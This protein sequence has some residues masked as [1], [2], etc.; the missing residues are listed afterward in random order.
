MELKNINFSYENN[1]PIL[2]DFNLSIQENKIT[3]I[4]G[5]SGVGKTTLLN[6][7]ANVIQP[8]SG[9]IIDKPNITSYLFQDDRLINEITVYK[10]LQLVLLS[11]LKDKNKINEEIKKYLNLVSLDD[12]ANK[13]PNE[14]SGSMRRRIALIR[15]FIYPS[16]LLL[17]DEPFKGLDLQLKQEIMETFVELY[18]FNPKTILFVT[19]DIDESIKIS[20]SILIMSN[21]PMKIMKNIFIKEN[22]DNR[23]IYT[24]EFNDIR[25]EIYLQTKK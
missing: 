12:C 16:K 11:V 24:K 6:L 4:I 17:M 21:S 1:K 13:Y 7:I 18:N 9:E 10:N 20:N 19:H 2:K 25:R 8:I 3:S 14:L 15:A 23:N 5:P 22:I